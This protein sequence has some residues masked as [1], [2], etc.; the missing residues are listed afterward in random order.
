MRRWFSFATWSTAWGL[1]FAAAAWAQTQPLCADDLDAASRSRRHQSDVKFYFENDLFAGTDRDYTNGVKLVWISPNLRDYRTDPC[2]PG[3]VRVLNLGLDRFPSS[4]K[5]ARNMVVTVGQAMFTPRERERVPP[6]PRDRPYAGWLYLGFGYNARSGE[7]MHTYEIDLG[8]IGPHAYAKTTQDTVH[9][10]RG[11][12]RFEG[13]GYQLGS[14]VGVLVVYEKKERVFAHALPWRLGGDAITHVGGAL[15]NVADYV[16]AGAE[17]RLGWS[18]PDD[19]GTSPIRPAGD[20]AAPTRSNEPRRGAGCGVHAFASLDVRA[21][22]HNIF[23]DGNTFHSSPHVRTRPLVGDMAVGFAW[24]ITPRASITYGHYVRT[25]EFY[26]Q[27][28]TH[29]FGSISLNV[30]F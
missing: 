14:E 19:F 24:S 17:L 4:G 16:N 5:D 12:A 28:S 27:P 7:A 29:A 2:L 8:V 25:K 26:G 6:D 1:L 20:N 10:M 23:L 30:R 13:W 22:A 11:I 18:I 3:W 9:D 15:G 21:V